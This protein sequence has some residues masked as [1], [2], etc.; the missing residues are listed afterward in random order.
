MVFYVR[1]FYVQTLDYWNQSLDVFEKI[2]D[3]VGIANIVGNIGAVYFNQGA[4]DKALEYTLKALQLAEKLGDTVRM[5]SASINV[6]AIYHNKKD[7][8]ALNYLLKADSAGGKS[9]N[10]D[11]LIKDALIN[12]TGNIGEIYFD[13]NDNQESSRIFQKSIKAA[14]T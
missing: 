12:I 14:G 10:K 9:D 6:G 4:D 1:G 5:I 3:D 2:K 13:N 8:V 11:A 7:P